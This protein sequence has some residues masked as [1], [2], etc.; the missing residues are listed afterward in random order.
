MTTILFIRLWDECSG[1]RHIFPGGLSRTLWQKYVK[2]TVKMYRLRDFD[3][4]TRFHN[5]FFDE[6]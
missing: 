1:F 5:V 3:P 4:I 2:N 6:D